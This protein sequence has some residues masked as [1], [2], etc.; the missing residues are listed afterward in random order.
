MCEDNNP[1]YNLMTKKR[2]NCNWC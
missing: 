1:I 2:T